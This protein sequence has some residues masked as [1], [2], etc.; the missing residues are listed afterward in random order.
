[1]TRRAHTHR[2]RLAVPVAVVLI[3]L[4][5]AA[6]SGASAT[7]PTGTSHP[8]VGPEAGVTSHYGR[9]VGRPGQ[10]TTLAAEAATRSYAVQ[11]QAATA[12]F[13]ASIGALR[14]DIAGGNMA[15]ARTD[16]L[17]AQADYD[18]FR[19]LERGN[20][21]NAST[22]DELD[23]DVVPGETF[24][25]LH[26]VERDLWSGGPA[27][28]DAAALAAQAPVAQ[29][30]L[31][32]LRLGPEAIASVA[33]D[34]LDWVVDTAL[35]YSQELSSHLGLV[36]VAGTVDAARQAFGDVAP[37]AR[38]VAP[39]LTATVTSDLATLE[40]DVTALG[41]PRTTPDISVTPAQRLAVSQQLDAT[42]STLARLTA[43]LTPYGTAGAPS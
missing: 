23:T 36:D 43:E 22:L 40:V 17:D 14:A 15:T 1:M 42:A 25:G 11:V 8:T 33:V 10:P 6:C 39:G 20:S 16:E 9:V 3:A 28:A 34:Q 41:P 30:L 19:D 18:A 29:Y 26:A 35:P 12:A 24:G 7:R 2:T 4:S 37:L 27:A 13:V 5:A 32:H 38:L 31:S 21:V